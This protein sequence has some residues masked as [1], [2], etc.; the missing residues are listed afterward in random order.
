MVVIILH[1]P[2]VDASNLLPLY[3]FIPLLIHFN[4]SAN[5]LVILDVGQAGLIL[6]AIGH[7][8]AFET[9]SSLDLANCKCL[10]LTF[11]LLNVQFYKPISSRTVLGPSSW[12][13]RH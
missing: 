5:I 2:L 6:I 9:L 11:F 8:Q 10:G 7:T 1:V 13:A 12:Q 4:F 3:E